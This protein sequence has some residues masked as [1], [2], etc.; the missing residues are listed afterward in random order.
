MAESQKTKVALV[1]CPPPNWPLPLQNRDWTGINID[2]SQSIEVG[3]RLMHEAKDAGATLITFPE[4]WF[5]G[6]PKWREQNDWKKTHLA[7]YIEN[8]LEIGSHEWNTLIDGIKSVGIWAAVAFSERSGNY[9]YMAQALISK[10]GEVVMHRRKLRPSGSERDMFSDGTVD[11]LRVVNTPLGRV[12]MLQCGEHFYPSMN[13]VMAAQRPKLH[14][15][16]W[17]F[18]LN[19]DDDTDSIFYNAS[20]VTRGAGSYALNSGAYVLMPSVGYCFIYDP[21]MRIVAAMD[22]NVDYQKHPILYHT[23][24]ISDLHGTQDHDPNAQASWAVLQQLN[25]AFPATIPHEQGSLVPRRETSIQYLT[26]TEMKWSEIAPGTPW[27]EN[28]AH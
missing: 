5:P 22:N 1:R 19:F 18:A 17:P 21:L 11:Q 10:D 7:S 2:I 8:S 15:G 24:G 14:I 9:I 26:S 23:L 3:L 13:F 16:A 28:L 27:P 6:F 20:L 25:D 12:G 4:L